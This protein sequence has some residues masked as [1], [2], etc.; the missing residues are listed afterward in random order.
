M[1]WL[2]MKLE[3]LTGSEN[4]IV[5]IVLADISSFIVL[6]TPKYSSSILL[7]EAG[8][9]EVRNRA[10]KP[11]HIQTA[12]TDC[13]IVNYFSEELKSLVAFLRIVSGVNES[14]MISVGTI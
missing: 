8:I 1:V 6:S 13:F 2:R 7:A 10:R 4:F 11:R 14:R 5:R 9:T 12:H 3:L